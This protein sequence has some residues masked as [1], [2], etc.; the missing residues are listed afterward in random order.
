MDCRFTYSFVLL[1]FMFR[2]AY[3]ALQNCKTSSHC[4]D[5][6]SSSS[7]ASIE[8]AVCKRWN[9][10]LFVMS[11][12]VFVSQAIQMRRGNYYL[13][14]NI[15]FFSIFLEKE[16]HTDLQYVLEIFLAKY[17]LIFLKETTLY[18][19]YLHSAIYIYTFLDIYSIYII[20]VDLIACAT[21]SFINMYNTKL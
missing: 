7:K 18:R 6:L 21:N 11:K 3:S 15:H 20:Y 17:S 2:L 16:I 19:I 10:P 1:D 5:N 4:F 14:K 8:V 12:V 13:K 9:E